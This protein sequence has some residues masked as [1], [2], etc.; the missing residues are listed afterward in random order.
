MHAS[1]S[2][3][4][5][6]RQ[7]YQQVLGEL[8]AAA[9]A[10]GRASRDVRLVAVTKYV[11]TADAV[12]LVEAGCFDLGESRPQVIWEKAASL[13]P[14]VRW[15]LIGHLQRNKVR[16]TL[17]QIHLLHSLDS[18]RLT[19]ALEREAIS[20]DI[21][22]AVLLE[23]QIARDASKTGMPPGEAQAWL[24][25]Y[26]SEEQLRQRVQL[27]GLMGMSSL[28]AD[29]SQVRSEFA[30]L[31]TQMETWNQ[32]FGLEMRELSMGMSQDFA[33]AIAEGSTM[34]R[35]G[36]RLFEGLPAADP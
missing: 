26:V 1:P 2:R 32:R 24:E 34:V 31:R 10:A 30:F 29:E 5:K 4:E 14:S 36:S 8:A 6:I 25:R 22:V 9:S 18:M 11:G 7:N 33:L 16:R 17:P 19:E 23:I 15:H 27:K 21:S 3:T 12:A 28:G 20:L 35:I 13:P